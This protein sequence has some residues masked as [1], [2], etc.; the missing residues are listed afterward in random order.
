MAHWS[1]NIYFPNPGNPLLTDYFVGL[2]NGANAKWTFA[3]AL[4]GMGVLPPDAV[5][6]RTDLANPAAAYGAALVAFQEP[7]S[8][9]VART[10]YSKLQDYGLAP[11]DFGA[12]ANGTADCTTSIRATIA[13]LY[14]SGGG[15]MVLRG[16]AYGTK[17]TIEVPETVRVVVAPSAYRNGIAA[18]KFVALSGFASHNDGAAVSRQIMVRTAGS[19]ATPMP[20]FSQ[21]TSSAGSGVEG[22]M[23]DMTALGAN[24]RGFSWEGVWCSALRGCSVTGMTDNTQAAYYIG[25]ASPT[26]GGSYWNV[27]D[28]ITVF[29]N[30]GTKRGT[31]LVL[32]GGTST[33][34]QVTQLQVRNPR[35]QNC[36]L[37][38]TIDHCGAGIVFICGGIENNV[39]NGVTVTNQRTTGAP[40]F[41][42]TEA[43]TNGGYGYSG[44]ILCHETTAQNNNGGGVGGNY[45][46]S[47][48]RMRADSQNGW[49]SSTMPLQAPLF[50]RSWDALSY[51]AAAT[52]TPSA[53]FL[54]VKSTGGAVAL[55][56]TQIAN[57]MQGQSITL[58]GGDNTD[59]IVFTNGGNINLQTAQF[60]L[61]LNYVL[62]LHW[63]PTTGTWN[64]DSR[65]GGPIFCTTGARP[66]YPDDVGFSIY[67]TTLNKPIWCKVKTFGSVVWVDATGASV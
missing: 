11:E 66:A 62:V 64:E 67:D 52:I 48:F 2:H 51:A 25:G 14:A 33:G 7:A 28:Q 30:S 38:V 49:Y 15:T 41:I 10:V 20:I 56:A 8:G 34:G 29:G 9:S 31:C 24:A 32:D 44:Y 45:D 21:S 57:G 39:G 4:A 13:A 59:F 53:E 40:V 22:L 6:L 12:V 46:A 55:G 61:K 19:S 42:G 1:D 50:L 37:G 63:H 26:V 16:P 58:I 43:S 17:D 23:L 18:C 3:Q 5:Q 65:K 54:R 47:V 35:F 60:A 36:N 27:L